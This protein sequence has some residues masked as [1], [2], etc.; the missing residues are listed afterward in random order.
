MWNLILVCACLLIAM[1]GGPTAARILMSGP[2][3][4]SFAAVVIAIVL[5][6]G[7]KSK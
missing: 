2:G 5:F 3:T 6:F 1:F 4:G 7:L